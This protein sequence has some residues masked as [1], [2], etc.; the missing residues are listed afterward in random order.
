[1]RV[2]Q[3]ASCVSISTGMH[4]QEEISF[5]PVGHNSEVHIRAVTINTSGFTN[6]IANAPHL[7]AVILLRLSGYESQYSSFTGVRNSSAPTNLSSF[8]FEWNLAVLVLWKEIILISA[9]ASAISLY[10]S[11]PLRSASRRTFE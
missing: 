1:M 5:L 2:T 3:V 8:F 11:I 4:R 9:A 6:A 7:Y 10:T